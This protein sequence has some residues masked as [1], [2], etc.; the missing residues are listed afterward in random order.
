MTRYW[1]VAALVMMAGIIDAPARAQDFP[2]RPITMIVPFAVGGPADITGRII[3][4]IFTRHL[5]QRVIGQ[6][7]ANRVGVGV[8]LLED[9]AVSVRFLVDG[10][11]ICVDVAPCAADSAAL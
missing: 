9:V 11:L 1:R 2:T 4:D 7:L 8:G 6:V 3:A 10:R 5:G